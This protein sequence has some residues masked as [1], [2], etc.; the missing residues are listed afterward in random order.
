MNQIGGYRQPGDPGFQYDEADTRSYSEQYAAWV[1]CRDTWDCDITGYPGCAAE[2]AT[3]VHIPVVVT[4][5][6]RSNG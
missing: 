4:K 3:E 6:D 1:L 5:R 2:Q